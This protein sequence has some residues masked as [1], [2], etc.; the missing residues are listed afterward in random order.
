MTDPSL[1]LGCGISK[2]S[3]CSTDRQP[4]GSSIQQLELIIL[5]NKGGTPVDVSDFFTHYRFPGLQ[6]LELDSYRITSWDLLT[7]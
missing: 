2:L 7:L 1:E 3:N 5:L 4:R 6:C